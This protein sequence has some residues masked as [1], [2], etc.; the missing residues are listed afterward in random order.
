MAQRLDR[1]R[2]LQAFEA[3]GADL[4]AH[5]RFVDHA[6]YDEAA[7]PEARARFASV[8]SGATA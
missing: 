7:P 4:A 6:I 8:V 5:G 3:L 2:L 1:T